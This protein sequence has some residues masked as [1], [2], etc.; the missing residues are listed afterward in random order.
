MIYAAD[1]VGGR[2]NDPLKRIGD[3]GG[4]V[5]TVEPDPGAVPF[6]ESYLSDGETAQWHFYALSDILTVQSGGDTNPPTPNPA[7][8][9]SAPAADSDSA[10]SMTAIIGSDTSGP[11]EYLFTETSGNAG[12]SSSSWQTSATYTDSGLSADTLYSYTVTLRDGIGNTGTASG[13]A[14]TTTDAPP[15]TEAPVITLLSPA[16]ETTDVAAGASL[17]ATF[18]ETIAAGT[19]S[20]ILTNLTK[21]TQTVID[22]ADGTQV[23]VSGT[24]LTID[25]AGDL[26]AGDS[27]AVNIDAGAVEDLAGNPFGGI[28]D[29][30]SWNFSI[31]NPVPIVSFTP[32]SG[33]GPESATPASVMVVLSHVYAG[34]VTV[35]HDLATPGGSATLD[36]DFTYT[37]GTLTFNEG[38][39]NKAFTFTVIDDDLGENYET[40]NF[41]LGTISNGVAGVVDSFA[42][43]I[44]SDAVDWGSIPFEEP[45]EALTSG[46]LS[47]QRGW[48]SEGGQVQTNTS[49]GGSLKAGTI[50]TSLGSIQHSFNG[51]KE[52]VWSDLRLQVV[53]MSAE[54]LPDADSTV[55]FYVATNSQVMVF[56]GTHAVSSGLT[57]PAGEWV[58][59]TTFSDYAAKTWTLYVND[60][61]A[62]PFGF[63][64]P[65]AS[66][67]RSFVVTGEGSFVDDL[68]VTESELFT[69]Y[70]SGGIITPLAW[71]LSYGGDPT[72]SD[73]DGDAL[74]LDQEYLIETDPTV[75]NEFKIINLRYLD[76]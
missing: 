43:T 5:Y 69:L 42:Y 47:G 1:E 10:I 48:V 70:A 33:F 39:T 9:A 53:H 45:F 44:L 66:G 25:P 34:T 40:I 31:T 27:Y 60:I 59:F 37:S 16:D 57:A 61:K 6:L 68:L 71:V 19:G 30:S 56:D 2:R 20:I 12:G 38:E 52:R 14:S 41:E 65:T 67:F 15:D 36:Q 54:P 4:G 64:D 7:T 8:F 46:D 18:N 51:A 63:L 58:R 73:Q 74:D 35:E 55:A 17:V 29:E 3:F 11:V 24:T 50:T 13:A 21:A 62:G 28:V 26:A 22:V 32:A 76:L 49:F 72:R 75:S 23:T